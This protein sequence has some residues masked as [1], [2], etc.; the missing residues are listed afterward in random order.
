MLHNNDNNLNIQYRVY[1]GVRGRGTIILY[2]CYW[3]FVG[4]WGNDGAW[5]EG[6]DDE[7]KDKEGGND[8]CRGCWEREGETESEGG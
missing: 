3:G 5:E 8:G 1:T 4:F 2:A 7:D 6:R